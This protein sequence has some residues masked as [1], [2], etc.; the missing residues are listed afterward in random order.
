MWKSKGTFDERN[1]GRIAFDHIFH[2][3]CIR[4]LFTEEKF[5]FVLICKFNSGPI[6]SLSGTLR[7]SYGCN[8]ML[9]FRSLSGLE[10]VLKTGIAAF[11]MASDLLTVNEHKCP[12]VLCTLQLP[13]HQHSSFLNYREL[14]VFCN[15]SPQHFCHGSCLPLKFRQ[16]HTLEV[17]LP[18]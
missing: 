4:Y 2:S 7:V 1:V 15:D 13:L 10:K 14:H 17:T 8:D 11:S 9:H 3:C 6:E 5:L 18:V 16:L 12:Q